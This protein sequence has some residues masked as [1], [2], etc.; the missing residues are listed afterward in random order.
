MLPSAKFSAGWNYHLK[1]TCIRTSYPSHRRTPWHIF[2]TTAWVCCW[3]SMGQACILSPFDPQC[4]IV[5]KKTI[6]VIWVSSHSRMQKVTFGER[7]LCGSTG[8]VYGSRKVSKEG[9]VRFSLKSMF[10]EEWL[11]QHTCA[12]KKQLNWAKLNGEKMAP[13]TFQLL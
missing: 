9:Q 4:N 5:P 10:L 13:N 7:G 8:V 1:Y 11:E 12:I 6:Y 3:K 2:T